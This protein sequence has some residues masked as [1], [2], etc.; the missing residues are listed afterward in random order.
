MS[1][2]PRPHPATFTKKGRSTRQDNNPPDWSNLV[3]PN[4]PK[5]GDTVHVTGK[6]TFDM[7]IDQYH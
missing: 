2:P 1:N 3:K 6:L 5:A 7:D 4:K